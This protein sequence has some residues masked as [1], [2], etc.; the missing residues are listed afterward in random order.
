[1]SEPLLVNYCRVRT[2]DL[3]EA[4]DH[5]GRTW[6]RHESHMR[7]GRSYQIAWHQADLKSTQLSYVETASAI[8]VVCGPVSQ[9][10]RLTMHDVGQISHRING[11]ATTSTPSRFVLHAPGQELVLET[12]PF[13]LLMLGLD[14]AFV[15]TVLA[16]R[17]GRLAPFETWAADFSSAFPA[18]STLQS[19]CRWTASELDQRPNGL[20]ALPGATAQLER[21]LLSLFIDCLAGLQPAAC[22]PAN[23]LAVR[24]LARIE[25]WIDTHFAD[26][27]GIEDLADVAGVSARA[28]Q[29]AFRRLRGC[30]PMQAVARR[31]LEAA[32]RILC[33]Q[34][35]DKTVTQVAVDC[36]FFHF[37]RFAGRYRE[38]FGET[39]SETLAAARRHRAD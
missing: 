28:V 16:R 23:D 6:E 31:R 5:V 20:I 18:A 15:D 9:S 7:R 12:E 29:M 8:R 32:R 33:S 39:P 34:P 14:G 10:Y 19:L 3:D 30:T 38:L 36:G 25:D 1:M 27:V 35:P 24:Q 4:R 22:E 26:P 37:G 17:F 2:R 13:A 21:T 11:R